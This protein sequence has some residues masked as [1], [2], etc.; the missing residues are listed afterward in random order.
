MTSKPTDETK[1]TP[2][3]RQYF[4]LKSE[5]GNA[6]LL[7]RLGNFYEMFGPDAETAS[8]ILG[9]T[10]TARSL[11]QS[12]KIPM[13]GVPYHSVTRY[14]KRL[15]DEGLTVAIADQMEDAAEAKGIVRRDVTRVITPGTIIEDEYLREE[16]GNYL[17]VVVRLRDRLGFAILESSGGMVY[18]GEVD[19][20]MSDMLA[21][22]IESRAPREL[23][24]SPDILNSPAFARLKSSL[25]KGQV[26][27]TGAFPS[28]KDLVYFA[29]RHF[30]APL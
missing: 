28:E 10:L 11:N 22:E 3:F 26:N 9:I 16:I 30:K 14:V 24:L 27:E 21:A 23:N 25:G 15:V 8:R 1:A 4:A 17:A 6:I 13:C 2:L 29:E 7:F 5:Y 18:V 19:A 20:G 12:E